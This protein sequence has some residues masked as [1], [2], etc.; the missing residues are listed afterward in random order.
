MRDESSGSRCIVENAA[1][2]ELNL[3][4]L[5]LQGAHSPGRHMHRC[6]AF[7]DQ[8][9][10]R[11][12]GLFGFRTGVDVTRRLQRDANLL[13]PVRVQLDV[14]EQL[15]DAKVRTTVRKANLEGGGFQGALIQGCQFQGVK[16]IAACFH[17]A[18]IGASRAASVRSR[19]SVTLPHRTLC[20][21]APCLRRPRWP[22]ARRQ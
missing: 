5:D 11:S 21:C 10:Q 20:P 8:A 16:L 2:N 22:Q 12:S 3:S 4:E 13:G 19:C 6:R 18:R 9:W 15:A 14:G 7:L 17:H 1:L